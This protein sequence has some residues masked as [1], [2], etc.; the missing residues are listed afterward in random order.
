VQRLAQSIP[1]PLRRLLFRDGRPAFGLRRGLVATASAVAALSALALLT[2]DTWTRAAGFRD[3]LEAASY[4][5][6]AAHTGAVRT[7][8]F[9][10]DGRYVATGSDD[11]TAAI[12]STTG[13]GAPIRLRGHGG[14]VT[15][16]T[17]SSDGAQVVTGSADS[18]VRVWAVDGRGELAMFKVGAP[19]TALLYAGSG[20]AVG[21]QD[22]VTHVASLETLDGKLEVIEPFRL[23]GS[24]DPITY[25]AINTDGSALATVSRGGGVRV[26]T[27]ESLDTDSTPTQRA[28]PRDTAGANYVA[29]AGLSRVVTMPRRPRLPFWTITGTPRR[30]MVPWNAAAIRFVAFAPD[31]Q[32]VVVGTG[33]ESPRLLRAG[34]GNPPVVLRGHT[35]P[36]TFIAFSPDG[37]RLV[38]ASETGTIRLWGAPPAIPV[39]IVGCNSARELPA[40]HIARRLA[41]LRARGAGALFSPAVIERSAWDSTRLGKIPPPGTIYYDG[42]SP[43]ERAAL[44]L[45]RASLGTRPPPEWTSGGPVPGRERPMTVRSCVTVWLYYKD[46]RDIPLALGVSDRL[47][48][49]GYRVNYN[50]IRPKAQNTDT[51][52][53]RYFHPEDAPLAQ[54]VREVVQDTLRRAGI[55]LPVDPLPIA[56]RTRDRDR[57]NP[58]RVE[59]WLPWLTGRYPAARR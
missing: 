19:V 39:N 1:E 7:A 6:L 10:P 32:S 55:R 21:T 50:G 17:F 22:G 33:D 58:E 37:Q 14:P 34:S 23:F 12:W 29:F 54:L 18:T 52:P 27:S 25:I 24:P 42:R 59:V 51:E 57:G 40:A 28:A 20:V 53:I 4:A 2:W 26:W 11:G 13:Q 15:Q 36:V 56:D 8:A 31:S 16:V 30:V 48:R 5:S 45:I 9:S 41:S 3:E 46:A 47:M 35:R 49:A 43:R 44:D 38:T